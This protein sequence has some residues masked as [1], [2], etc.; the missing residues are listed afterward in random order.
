MKA[1]A[2]DF[3]GQAEFV[4]GSRVIGRQHLSGGAARGGQVADGTGQ[5]Q[6]GEAPEDRVQDDRGQEAGEGHEW[7]PLG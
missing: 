7:G 3:R 4:L 1:E 6:Q 5:E 2:D